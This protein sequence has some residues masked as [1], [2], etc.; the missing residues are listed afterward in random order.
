MPDI[1]KKTGF[2]CFDETLKYFVDNE[3]IIPISIGAKNNLNEQA[4]NLFNALNKFDELCVDIIYSVEP[5][6]IEIGEA[7]YN[8]LIK[9]AGGKIIY[10]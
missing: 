1:D 3:N 7:I 10:L 9:A 4:K 6:K 5:M 8:R 2:L